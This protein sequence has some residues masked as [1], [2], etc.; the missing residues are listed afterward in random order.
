[1][2]EENKSETV[3]EDKNKIDNQAETSLEVNLKDL[4]ETEKQEQVPLH[5]LQKERRKRQ[6]LEER[7]RALEEIQLKYLQSMQE[8]TQPAEEDES[9]YEPVLKNEWRKELPNLEAQMMRNFEE[10]MWIKNNSDL[11]EVVAEKL[12]DF[13][14]QKPYYA[15]A[16]KESSNRYETAWEIMDKFTP[17][18][19]EKPRE[20]ANAPNSPSSIP[21]SGAIN[22]TVEFSK[23]SDA[24]YREYRRTH[25][26][27]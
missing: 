1:M 16:I 4:P 22:A 6:E 2:I 18:K 14:K 17:K 20:P 13:L 15:A 23:M 21:K 24:E 5:V 11:A 10:K 12:G 8:K 27:H 3:S 9:G 7:N 26:R 19:V 25:R